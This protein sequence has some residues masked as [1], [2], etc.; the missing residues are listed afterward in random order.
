MTGTETGPRHV[1]PSARPPPVIA[2][3]PEP[4]IVVNLLVLVNRPAALTRERVS[5]QMATYHGIRSYAVMLP[6]K[7]PPPATWP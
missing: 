3:R 7:A 2:G 5:A 4:R 1:A 6:A